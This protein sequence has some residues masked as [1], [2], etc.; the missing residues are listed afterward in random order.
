MPTGRRFHLGNRRSTRTEESI[1]TKTEGSQ[2]GSIERPARGHSMGLRTGEQYLNGLKG[3]GRQIWYDG[4]QIEDVTTEPGLRD[5]ALTVAQYYDFQNTPGLEELMTYE[6]PDGDRAHLSFIEPRSVDDL[7]RRGAAFGAWA[8]VTGGLM[9]R[10]PDYMNACM[11]MVGAAS[12]H[13]GRNDPRFG[14]NAYETYRRCRTDD[15]CM[16]H[17]FIAPMV[18]RLTT[19]G[20][21][22]ALHQRRRG[23]TKRRRHRRQ[24][25]PDGRHAGP[26][27][28]RERVVRRPGPG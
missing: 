16:T 20:R 11:M 4:R 9:G 23:G 26:V 6:T 2:S 3:D 13:W 18:D 19:A 21:A 1:D 24:R 7:R 10:A 5:T 12:H 14:H 15:I 22:G 27:L 17:T 25:S 8:E 28:R